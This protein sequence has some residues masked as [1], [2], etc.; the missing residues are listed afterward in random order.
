MG[1]EISM[2]TVRRNGFEDGSLASGF[3]D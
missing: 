1:N 2:K 3:E